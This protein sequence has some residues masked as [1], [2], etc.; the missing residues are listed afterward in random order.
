MSNVFTRNDVGEPE[1]QG[2]HEYILFIPL[3]RMLT[4]I[5]LC[6]VQGRMTVLSMEHYLTSSDV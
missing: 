6:T 3:E 1:D 5:G 2:R 4:L